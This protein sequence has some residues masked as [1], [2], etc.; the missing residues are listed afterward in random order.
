MVQH[1]HTTILPN[2]AVVGKKKRLAKFGPNGCVLCCHTE[3]YIYHM[4]VYNIYVTPVFFRQTGHRRR[5]CE[6]EYI[7][8][9]FFVSRVTWAPN[10]VSLGVSPVGPRTG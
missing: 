5:F 6:A 1:A 8:Y 2:L 4:S 3:C 7:I 10:H 9:R